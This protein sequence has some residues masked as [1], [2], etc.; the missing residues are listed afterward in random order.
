MEVIFL[1]TYIYYGLILNCISSADNQNYH[2]RD[3]IILI[4]I[5]HRNVFWLSYILRFLMSLLNPYTNVNHEHD[6][7]NNSV[8]K[9]V[10]SFQLAETW[11]YNWHSEGWLP[12]F[13]SHTT[14]QERFTIPQTFLTQIGVRL[15]KYTLQCSSSS[16]KFVEN[17]SFLHAFSQS[18]ITNDLDWKAIHDDNKYALKSFQKW[19]SSYDLI[20]EEESQ[21]CS[22]WRQWEAPA[23]RTFWILL[24][25]S[26]WHLFLIKIGSHCFEMWV[27]CDFVG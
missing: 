1:E 26:S 12:G 9:S 17:I 14:G 11:F 2:N 5:S 21:L 19:E 4:T 27:I 15:H 24:A 13:K 25:F 22:H 7:K 8:K 20:S 18:L 16:W 6:G 23:G 3:S 10:F